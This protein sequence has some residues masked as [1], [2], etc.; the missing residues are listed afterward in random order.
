MQKHLRLS[1]DELK[2]RLI[3]K[4]GILKSKEPEPSHPPKRPF[5]PQ[6]DRSPPFGKPV[7][8]N[9]AKSSTD[10][11]SIPCEHCGRAGH[12]PDRCW[13]KFPELKHSNVSKRP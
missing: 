1:L 13:K 5:T 3:S 2:A 4:E 12:P 11:K 6:H 9:A 7:H 8:L 10:F